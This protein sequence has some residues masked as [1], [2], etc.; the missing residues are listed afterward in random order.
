MIRKM[1]KGLPNRI[2]KYLSERRYV[3][4]TR[5]KSDKKVVKKNIKNYDSQFTHQSWP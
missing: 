1:I 2:I 5:S 4:K 3:N